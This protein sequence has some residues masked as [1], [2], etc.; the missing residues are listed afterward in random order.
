VSNHADRSAELRR[1]LWN[2]SRPAPS[3]ITPSDYDATLLEQYKLYVEMADRVS[4]RRALANTFF[5]SLN[6]AV[7]TLAGAVWTSNPPGQPWWLLIPLFALL[8]ECFAWY[9]VVRSYRLLNSAK[10]EVVGAME[11]RLPASPYWRA[12]WWALG[13]GTDPS[14]YWPLSHIEQWIPALFALAYLAGGL[15]LIGSA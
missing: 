13:E 2:D 7:L 15:A 9:Y 6:T 1:R 5:L 14:R 10:F 3:R 4:Q 8:G 11:E 12:E